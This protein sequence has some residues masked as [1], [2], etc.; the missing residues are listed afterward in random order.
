[1]LIDAGLSARETVRRLDEAGI[2]LEQ[3]KAILVS[4]EHSDHIAG[5]RVLHRKHGLP[6]YA[7]RGT[8][9]ALARV[10]ALDGLTPTLFTTGFAFQ[11]GGLTIEP[12]SVPHDAYEPVGFVL[13]AGDIR[14]GVVT[15]MGIPTGVIRARLADCHAIV[16]ESN[17]DEGMLMDAERPWYLK[18]RIRG[19]QGHLSNQAAA[20][21]LGEVAGPTLRRVYLAHLS[22]D[23]N[24]SHLAEREMRG[25]LERRGFGHVEVALTYPDRISEVWR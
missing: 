1:V 9:D 16:I 6:V 2:A 8:A 10:Q 5:I 7:N 12:F 4:H 11:L 21:L 14:V 17:H 24:R 13:S 23:C 18:Q 19:R 22:E 20:R 25:T 15:D 3:V